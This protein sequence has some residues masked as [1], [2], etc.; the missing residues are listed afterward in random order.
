MPPAR[1]R[2]RA[3]GSANRQDSIPYGIAL[4]AAPRLI[5]KHAPGQSNCAHGQNL[6]HAARKRLLALLTEYGE[7]E[8]P[9]PAAPPSA[10]I[11]PLQ[12]AAEWSSSATAPA[13]APA[14]SRGHAA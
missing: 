5:F 9:R 7:I 2:L 1:H 14:A 4:D 3:V 13:L 12:D 10:G 11:S 8:V 6:W